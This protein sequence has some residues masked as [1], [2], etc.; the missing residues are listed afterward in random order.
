LGGS[1]GGSTGGGSGDYLPITGGTVTGN[2][3]ATGNITATGNM[4]AASF[5]KEGGTNT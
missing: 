5:V 1:T 4:N 2:I 3:A